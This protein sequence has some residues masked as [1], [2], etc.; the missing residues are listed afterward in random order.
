[1]KSITKSLIVLLCVL[2]C[3]GGVVLS[4]KEKTHSKQPRNKVVPVNNRERNRV[5]WVLT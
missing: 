4:Q 2:L 1:M 5:A 3:A